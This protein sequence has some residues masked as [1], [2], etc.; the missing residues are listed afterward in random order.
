MFY[1]ENEGKEM[2]G[3]IDFKNATMERH[4]EVMR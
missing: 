1:K 3:T 4:V 2:V